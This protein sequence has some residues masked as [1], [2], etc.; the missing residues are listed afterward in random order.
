MSIAYLGLESVRQLKNVRSL[1]FTFAIPLVMLLRPGNPGVILPHLSRVFGRRQ[2]SG[3][4]RDERC[5][6][7]HPTSQAQ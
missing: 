2:G 7:T 4:S 6:A 1:I 5:D 3:W